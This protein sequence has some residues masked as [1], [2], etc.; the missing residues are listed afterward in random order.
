MSGGG[1]GEGDGESDDD[2][3]LR[4]LSRDQVRLPL[5]RSLCLAI[6]SPEQ[7]LWTQWLPLAQRK[8]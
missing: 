4:Q 1:E 7:T 2:G 5:V 3:A 6:V 8:A